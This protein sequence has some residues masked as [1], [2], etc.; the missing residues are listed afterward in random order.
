MCW[1]HFKGTDEDLIFSDFFGS[2][3]AVEAKNG[4]IF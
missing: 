1:K 3:V 4:A 2:T